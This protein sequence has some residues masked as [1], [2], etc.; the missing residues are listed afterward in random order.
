M[1]DMEIFHQLGRGR[2]RKANTLVF[3]DAT[4]GYMTLVTRIYNFRGIYFLRPSSSC[5]PNEHGS[6]ADNFPVDWPDV[7]RRRNG[8]HRLACRVTAR[9]RRQ[10]K[11]LGLS[12]EAP[13]VKL[14]RK[15]ESAIRSSSDAALVGI[16]W[17]P[18]GPSAKEQCPQC[19]RM[20]IGE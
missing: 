16:P 13:Q 3:R 14:T 6:R 12:C 9:R 19:C 15:S 4:D 20:G 2:S 1:S 7:P 5:S 11:N 17:V 18:A 10:K 8:L